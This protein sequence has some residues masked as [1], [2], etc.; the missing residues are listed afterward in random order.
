MRNRI[1]PPRGVLGATIVWL[2]LSACGE[3]GISDTDVIRQFP[4]R[5]AIQVVDSLMWAEILAAEDAR[6]TDPSQLATLLGALDASDP[7]IR[8]LA[9]RAVG[10]LEREELA[11]HV[12]GL[13]TDVDTKVRIEGANALAQSV[14]GGR[15]ADAV[16]AVLQTR[17]SEE[18]EPTVRGAIAQ[19]LGRLPYGR[20]AAFRSVETMLLD[21]LTDAPPEM[22]L[23]LARGLESL[24][25]L[26]RENASPSAR[27]VERLY[28]LTRFRSTEHPLTAARVRRLSLTA[29]SAGGFVDTTLLRIAVRDPDAEVRRLAAVAARVLL[30]GDG[31]MPIVA[32][33]LRDDVAWVRYAALETYGRRM[34]RTD[35]CAAVSEAT[36]DA[37]VH[38]S[39][40]AIELLGSRCGH[41]PDAVVLLAREAGAL[42]D[43]LS[44]AWHR[45]T[46]ALVALAN[47]APDRA[48]AWLAT[49]SEH[50]SWWVRTYAARAATVLGDVAGLQRLAADTNDNVRAAAITGLERVVGHE[51]DSTY[52]RQLARPDYQL[53]ITAAGLLRGSPEGSTAVPAILTSLERITADRRETSRDARR[54]LMARLEEFAGPAQADYLASYL[55]DF[56]PVVATDVARILGRWTGRAWTPDPRPDPRRPL[57][58]HGDL[59][60]LGNL[61]AV[62]QLRGGET[63]ELSLLPYEAPTNAARFAR[64]A[65]AGYYDGLTFHRVV[66]GF[67][68]QG[69]SPGAN[70]YMG[71]G[72]YTRDE[73][74]KESHLRGTVGVSTRGRDT[75]D[76]QIFINLVDNPRLDHI[77][78]IFAEVVS[79]MEVVDRILEGA[80][81]ERITFR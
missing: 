49:F 5:D 62:V 80:V 46:R 39:L 60:E 19:A 26:N 12:T 32:T 3:Q 34:T 17:F 43:G 13:L 77:Y 37:D 2:S 50:E 8:A 59:V 9:A 81:I 68:I 53:V 74:V 14:F 23:G 16:L 66:P 18:S 69:G 58:S 24:V 44:D 55:R 51:A 76:A 4:S 38:V 25:R 65:R 73:L 67:V 54:A 30:D 33:A 79:G 27:T 72:P 47:A 36:R 6:A 31:W 61:V 21:A 56:D 35:G 20:A 63:F 29:L 75:G 41:D 64:L 78:T 28:S 10:R 57:P 15:G 42:Q 48:Q 1:N 70:E 45:P 7:A 71:D 40:L 52:A 22:L 11:E